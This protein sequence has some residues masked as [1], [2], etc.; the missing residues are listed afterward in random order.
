MSKNCSLE[1]NT[2]HFFP[3]GDRWETDCYIC[4]LWDSHSGLLGH[5][6]CSPCWKST[7][8]KEGI[9]RQQ[10][11]YRW[12]ARRIKRIASNH[13]ISHTTERTNTRHDSYIIRYFGKP[14]DP[15]TTCFTLVSAYSSTIIMEATC[16][17]EASV[18]FQRTT[19]SFASVFNAA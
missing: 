10:F 8:K 3:S 16:S 7:D 17:S 11:S 12:L 15:L 9:G 2:R 18:N 5:N 19:H 13:W 14:T 4:R 1:E 6:T